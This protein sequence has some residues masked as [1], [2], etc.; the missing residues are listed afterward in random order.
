MQVKYVG[1]QTRHRERLY[2]TGLIFAGR[3]DVQEVEDETVARKMI[4]RHPDQ[5]AEAGTTGEPG[6]QV[7][8]TATDNTGG[9]SSDD[10]GHEILIGDAYKP[11]KDAT[12]NELEAYAK[13]VFEV[14]LDKR[15]KVGELADEVIALID[16]AKAAQQGQD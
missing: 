16:K 11:V 3:G 8:G 5:Y 12:K 14:D 9:D 4:A 6:A 7:N 13:R 2:G 15:K 1:R 10:K